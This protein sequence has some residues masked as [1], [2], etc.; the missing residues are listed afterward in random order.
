MSLDKSITHG[1]ESRKSYQGAKGWKKMSEFDNKGCAFSKDADMET[2][3]QCAKEH[4]MP[5]E[6]CCLD[7]CGEFEFCKGCK[8]GIYQER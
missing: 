1:K 8:S 7:F 3:K 5:Y 6:Q 2:C 4:N